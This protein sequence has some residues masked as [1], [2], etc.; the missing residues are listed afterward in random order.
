[1]LTCCSPFIIPLDDKNFSTLVSYTL[2]DGYK[3]AILV[4]D[5]KPKTYLQNKLLMTPLPLGNSVIFVS[6]TL[7][8]AIFFK[9]FYAVSYNGFL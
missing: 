2:L 5:L 3:D 6:N 1:M 7:L 9:L 8:N 4:S